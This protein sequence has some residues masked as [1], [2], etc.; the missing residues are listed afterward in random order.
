MK[1]IKFLPKSLA[2]SRFLTSP[3][4]E[5]MMT[6]IKCC[7]HILRTIFSRDDINVVESEIMLMTFWRPD[8]TW[9]HVKAKNSEGEPVSFGLQIQSEFME[10]MMVVLDESVNRT[11]DSHECY[12]VSFETVDPFHL[13]GPIHVIRNGIKRKNKIFKGPFTVYVNINTSEEPY[14]TLFDDLKCDNPKDMQNKI[15]A[16]AARKMKF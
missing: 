9:V 12:A 1:D 15:I 14:K 5:I 6:D 7:E 16:E 11:K 8:S 2:S 4:F 13:N 10:D 3:F